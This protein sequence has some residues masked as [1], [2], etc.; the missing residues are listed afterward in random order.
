MNVI[1]C[2]WIFRIKHWAN[3]S[4]ERYKAPLVAKGFHQQEGN[5]YNKIFS[6]VANLVTI[7]IVISLIVSLDLDMHQLD[8][9]NSFLNG[10]LTGTI[11]MI[12]PT[13][14]VDPS[15]LNIVYKLHKSLTNSSRYAG[16]GLH[17][18]LN[19]LSIMAL[20]PPNQTTLFLFT[21]IMVLLPICLYM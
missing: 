14:F 1:E 20:L 2:K 6:L 4:I 15:Q 10:N 19:F 9:H 13:G 7:R 16:L 11:Y 5:G 18:S 12:E 3:D 21:I 17:G 8:V